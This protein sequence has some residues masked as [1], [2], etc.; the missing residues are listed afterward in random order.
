MTSEQPGNL[1]SNGEFSFEKSLEILE[2]TPNVISKMIIGISADWTMNSEGPDTWNVHDVIGHLI[3]CD[4][5]NWMLRVQYLLNED[6]PGP[7]SSF[8]R[9][10]HLKLNKCKSVEQLSEQFI[11][12]RMESL[13]QLQNLDLGPDDM[14]RKGCHPQLGEVLLSELLSA[15]VVHDLGHISQIVRVMAKQYTDNVGPWIQY[16]SILK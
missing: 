16:L 11:K 13:R 10:G 1:I 5:E 7:F 3:Y 12:T 8:D 9:F 4:T 14:R 6:T 15:W 2:R